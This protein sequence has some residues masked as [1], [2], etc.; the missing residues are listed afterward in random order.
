MVL[1]SVND[2]GND[3]RL[4]TSRAS[5]LFSILVVI[6]EIGGDAATIGEVREDTNN[7]L[8][9]AAV[10]THAT[11]EETVETDADDAVKLASVISFC[12]ACDLSFCL[13]LGGMAGSSAYAG[14]FLQEF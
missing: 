14:L 8:E 9:P 5:L 11:D 6:L 12:A 2:D 13:R 4:S 10:T 3:D 7:S 1:A